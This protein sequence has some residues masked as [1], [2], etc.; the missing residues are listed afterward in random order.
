MMNVDYSI[1]K[2]QLV[3]QE[4]R[5]RR[6]VR[7]E[8]F[9]APVLQVLSLPKSS[10]CLVLLDPSA[11]KKPTFENLFKVGSDGVIE[12]KAA[13]PQLHDAFV[14]VVD[15]DDHVEARTWKG[16]RVEIDLEN[17]RTKSARFVK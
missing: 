1:E 10:S 3:I 9:E 14:S 16:E 6:V 8:T 5:T 2:G 7:R 12:W 15:C 13:L 11:S 17:G 4:L